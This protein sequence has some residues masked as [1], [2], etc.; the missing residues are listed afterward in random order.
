[1]LVCVI[2]SHISAF[3]AL[4]NIPMA[5]ESSAY[6]RLFSNEVFLRRALHFICIEYIRFFGVRSRK[7][8]KSD[9]NLNKIGLDQLP[10]KYRNK[11]ASG[12][13]LVLIAIFFDMRSY[14][15]LYVP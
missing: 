13:I 8:P 15:R 10:C 12:E 5:T 1:M 6:L 11:C 2:F 3:S 9:T 4:A 7:V 14:L